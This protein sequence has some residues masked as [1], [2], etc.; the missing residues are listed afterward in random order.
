[1]AFPVLPVA[2][3]LA[4]AYLLFGSKKASAA[5][6]P[7]ASPSSP[8]VP[9]SSPYV[10]PSGGGGGSP[11]GS[12][13]V[14]GQIDPATGTTYIGPGGGGSYTPM[15]D[16]SGSGSDYVGPAASATGTSPSLLDQASS[17]MDSFTTSGPPL[18]W[19]DHV[20]GW[21]PYYAGHEH[22]YPPPAGLLIF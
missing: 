7:G 15:T 6:P 10:P 21:V 12:G 9:P 14:P 1:M 18:V 8:Y 3:G 20:G 11:D 5:T 22:G 19:S 4:G 16:T 2:L 17:W 13:L